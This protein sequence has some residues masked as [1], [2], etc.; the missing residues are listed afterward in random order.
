VTDKLD[1]SE[2][3]RRLERR[4]AAEAT[5]CAADF[6]NSALTDWLWDNREALIRAAEERDALLRCVEAADT[7]PDCCDYH[8][9]YRAARR[10]LDA[11]RSGK[12]RE[13]AA[14]S[15]PEKPA[16]TSQ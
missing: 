1:V 10:A 6:P 8:Q 12:P 15:E 2:G 5:G 14:E 3:R 16:T 11:L 7:V 4:L 13:D 9:E